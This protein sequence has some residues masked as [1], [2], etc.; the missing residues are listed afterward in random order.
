LLLA[1][2]LSF[3][4]LLND[5]LLGA[6]SLL[7][8]VCLLGF[9]RGL[10]KDRQGQAGGWLF[11]AAIKPQSVVLPG[12]MLASS[13]RWRALAMAVLAGIGMV[14]ISS[15][16]IGWNAWPDY[17]AKLSKVSRF[18]GSYGI[19]PNVM[20]NLR[21]GLT[22]LLSRERAVVINLVSTL[23]LAAAALVIFLLWLHSP[24]SDTP[25]FELRLAFTLALGLFTSPHLNPQDGLLYLAPGV[26]FYDYLRR[27][28]SISRKLFAAFSLL[29]PIF[30]LFTEYNLRDR[31]GLRGP[32]VAAGV[33]VVWVGVEMLRG[34]KIRENGKGKENRGLGI[35]GS[36][37]QPEE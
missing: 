17:L 2:G 11:L 1:I 34:I 26:F 20:Y 7:M 29:C 18:F 21:G 10:Q 3:P 22:T 27:T 8:L 30:I 31:L 9:A 5:L 23:S 19:D 32:V 12:V 36:F 16:C 28:E 4:P 25:E 15:L 24:Q 13:R 37:S 6:F 14:L 33:L 35:E